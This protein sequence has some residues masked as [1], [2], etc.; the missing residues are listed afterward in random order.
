MKF[1]V[2]EI[3][4]VVLKA[5]ANQKVGNK[6][7]YKGEPVIYFDTLKTSSMEGAATTVYAQGGRGNSRLVAWEGERT[8]TFTMEDAL[9]SPAGFM[10]L[11]GAGLIEAT[12]SKP[13]YVH[14]TEQTDSTE[15]SMSGSNLQ[16]DIMLKQTPA[17]HDDADIYVMLLDDNGEVSSEPFKAKKT[18]IAATETTTA[19]TVYR[20]TFDKADDNYTPYSTQM[21]GEVP[22]AE[23]VA[24]WTDTN[25]T[26]VK[27]YKTS[28]IPVLVDYY[29]E[30]KS[31]AQQIDITPDKFGGNYYLEASTL[32]RTQ[33]GVDMPAEFIIPNCKIQSNFTF[34]MAS[35]GDPSSFTFTMD[36][37]PDYTRFDRSKK[38]LAAIQIIDQGI[39]TTELERES[40][41]AG[42]THHADVDGAI[43]KD[44]DTAFGTAPGSSI[45][46]STTETP[47][48]PG[49]GEDSGNNG[50]TGG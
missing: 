12:T 32:F 6:I 10:I 49:D 33:A 26:A 2:R 42:F 23:L 46:V 39:G 19:K 48:E 16:L 7:F 40:T 37:F 35:S 43:V 28:K 41:L 18:T 47:K 30:K 14:V 22:L 5:K 50:N 4:D 1:G 20:I 34:T 9:I 21:N 17:E 11:S 27:K 13:I 45:A 25:K 15:L 8:V 44:K 31:G 29:T 24:E 3:C 38:V 36:A